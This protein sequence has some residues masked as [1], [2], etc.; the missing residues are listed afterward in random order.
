MESLSEI[1]ENTIFFDRGMDSLRALQL[2][3]IMRKAVGSPKLALSTGYQNPTP[4]QLAAAIA[5]NLGDDPDD[6][7]SPKVLEQLLA[8]Y[9]GLL[10]E[11]PKVPD[12]GF[13]IP[14]SLRKKGLLT[15]S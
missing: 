9:R 5:S 10:Q 3:R 2:V 4:R 15:S 12:T 6:H 8:T 1:E 7:D 14:K 11:V 13:L